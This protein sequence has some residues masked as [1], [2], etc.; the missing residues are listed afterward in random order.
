MRGGFVACTGDD[1]RRLEGI[2]KTLRWRRG[3]AATIRNERGLAIAMFSDP[4]EGPSVDASGGL[5]RLTHGC[6]PGPIG[7]LQA[8]ERRFAALEWNGG[9]LRMTRDPFGLAPLFYR[10]HQGET[11]VATEIR[12]LRAVGAT[13]ADLEALEAQA[14]FVP[15]D[16]RTGWQGIFRVLPGSTVEIGAGEVRS[17]NRYWKPADM[18]RRFSGCR[19]DAV[20]ELRDRFRAAVTACYEPG[21]ALL[22]S[23]GLDSAAVCLVATAAAKSPPRLMHAHFADA[24]ETHEHQYANAVADAVGLALQIVP[25]ELGPWDLGAEL[26]QAV[27]HPAIVFTDVC[28]E[29]VGDRDRRTARRAGHVIGCGKREGHV[30]LSALGALRYAL[31]R[32]IPRER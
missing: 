15:F 1:A 4:R 23:G 32:Q 28:A 9:L 31:H 7:D 24:P 30:G 17:I 8:R 2:L 27:L 29:V 18:M 26:D 12:V 21:S 13:G 20:A 3:G 11:W 6:V 22:L 25:G 10:I 14:A 16:E 5:G 19:S